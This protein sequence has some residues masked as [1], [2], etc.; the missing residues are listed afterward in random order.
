MK[1]IERLKTKKPDQPVGEPY[2]FEDTKEAANFL[3]DTGAS[4][5]P[6][7]D[8]TASQMVTVK[9]E[10]VGQLIA[11]ELAKQLATFNLQ[12]NHQRD[13]SQSG[14][15]RN[16]IRDRQCYWCGKYGHCWITSGH[17]AKGKGGGTLIPHHTQWNARYSTT[18]SNVQRGDPRRVWI[19]KQECPY[20]QLASRRR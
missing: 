12:N 10:D 6:G 11:Q 15:L 19:R 14:N 3:L 5:G 18:L 1:L 9:Q 7:V 2:E 4:Y 13:F 16:E 20:L 8:T 17:V